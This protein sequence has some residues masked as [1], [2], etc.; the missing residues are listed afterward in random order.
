MD[1]I[2]K[3]LLSFVTLIYL[4]LKFIKLTKNIL[5]QYYQN[6]LYVY[7]KMINI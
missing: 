6:Q 7:Q 4:C 1:T 2:S 5:L 3:I